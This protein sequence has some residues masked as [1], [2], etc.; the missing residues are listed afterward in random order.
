MD[1]PEE[2]SEEQLAAIRAR[3][4]EP[5]PLIALTE[6][7][8]GRTALTEYL[9]RLQDDRVALVDEIDRLREDARQRGEL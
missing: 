1:A 8:R 4:E 7:N 6:R 9:T 2:L 5:P 3:L